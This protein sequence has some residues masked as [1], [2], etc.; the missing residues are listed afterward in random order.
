VLSDA[1]AHGERVQEVEARRDV[2]GPFGQPEASASDDQRDEELVAEVAVHGTRPVERAEQGLGCRLADGLRRSPRLAE[3]VTDED[4][5]L[6][7]RADDDRGPGRARTGDRFDAFAVDL[8]VR[9]VER[10]RCGLGLSAC[11]VRVREI[12][13][14]DRTDGDGFGLPAIIEG[15]RLRLAGEQVEDD[16]AATF[17][18]EPAAPGLECDAPPLAPKQWVLSEPVCVHRRGPLHVGAPADRGVERLVEFGREREEGIRDQGDAPRGPDVD[19]ESAA[20]ERAR[21]ESKLLGPSLRTLDVGVRDARDGVDRR[22]V[23]GV[24]SRLGSAAPDPVDP[25]G[26]S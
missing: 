8:D 3:R 1:R 19:G 20:A 9:L 10:P 2:V 12:V 21:I 24:Q 22:E 23:L 4:A 13:R 16:L 17:G 7:G 14:L 26:V 25:D 6:D 18:I 15:T 5:V 11:D